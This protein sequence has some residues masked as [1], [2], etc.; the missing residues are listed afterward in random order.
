MVDQVADGTRGCEASV[1]PAAE[2]EQRHRA[3]QLQ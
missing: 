1:D 2:A 3:A